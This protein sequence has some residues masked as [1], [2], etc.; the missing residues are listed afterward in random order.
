MLTA[1][2]RRSAAR[3]LEA[4]WAVC[5][6]LRQ[7]LL[8]NGRIKVSSLSR[9]RYLPSPASRR[10][11]LNAKLLTDGLQMQDQYT[12]SSSSTIPVATTAG[13]V[14]GAVVLIATVIAALLLCCRRRTPSD[15]KKDPESRADDPLYQ[16]SSRKLDA[17]AAQQ[18][19]APSGPRDVEAG[20]LTGSSTAPD[21]VHGSGNEKTTGSMFDAVAIGAVR[22]S[23]PQGPSGYVAPQQAPNAGRGE[24]SRFFNEGPSGGSGQLNEMALRSLRPLTPSEVSEKL[25]AM[26]VGAALVAALEDDG[27]NGARLPLLDDRQLVA[28]GI[29]QPIS[30][31]LILQAVQAVIQNAGQGVGSG[32]GMNEV[33][34]LPRYG[35]IS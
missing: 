20:F 13:G 19:A 5:R 12:T 34:D 32:S 1:P 23:A 2:Q 28:L 10:R 9:I 4:A 33:E 29:D 14:A 30:R 16:S 26:G 22:N 7:Q 3:S 21:E 27:V 15:S 25:M 18:G 31:Q 8:F 35:T 6:W 24:K 17:K 11:D